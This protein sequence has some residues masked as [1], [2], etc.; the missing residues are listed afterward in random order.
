MKINRS[1][2]IV[3]HSVGHDPFEYM[4]VWKARFFA[5]PLRQLRVDLLWLRHPDNNLSG[6]H[7]TTAAH[8]A[9]IAAKTATTNKFT[10]GTGSGPPVM[11][12]KHDDNGSNGGE[13]IVDV[14]MDPRR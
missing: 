5:L 6:A 3:A 4:G 9:A 13:D 2:T 10:N 14:F 8:R 12:A 11:Y 1:I 7:P